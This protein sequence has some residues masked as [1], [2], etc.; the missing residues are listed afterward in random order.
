M[1]EES[2]FLAIFGSSG[3]SGGGGGGVNIYNADGTILTGRDVTITDFVNFGKLKIDDSNIINNMIL[4]GY[5]GVLTD[6][7]NYNL[8][9]NINGHLALNSTALINFNMNN[10]LCGKL[11]NDTTWS[12]G[13]QQSKLGSAK[14]EIKSANTLSTA[15]ALQIYDGDGTPSLLWD[16]RNNG[17]VNLGKDSVITLNN[18]LKIESGQTYVDNG[19]FNP[20]VINRK[21]LG[22]LGNGIDFNA[23]NSSNAETN[24]ARIV[25]VSTDATAGSEDGGLWL[26]T[27]IAGTL[28]TPVIL[29]NREF[30][31]DAV[32]FTDNA[33]RVKDGTTDCLKVTTSKQTYIESGGF[34]PLVINYRGSGVNGVGIDLNAYNSSNVEHNFAR[35]VQVA[36]DITTASEDGALWLRVSVNGTITTKLKINS[37]SVD[38]EDTLDM[39]NNRITNTVVN[40][41]VQEVVSSATF[42]VNSDEET[43]GFLT[44]MAVAT[45]IASPTGT[46]VQGQKLVYRL[47]D[48]GTARALT[49]NAIFR[50]IGVTLPTTTTASKLLYVGCFYNNTDTKWDVISVQEEA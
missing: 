49:W 18:T 43:M 25:Q 11:H 37:D 3:S 27:M 21:G 23:Y 32:N 26:R 10:V 47:K 31:I 36:T 34:N 14:V 24:F 41:S 48:D 13:S 4:L 9:M 29:D 30:L 38:I 45:T 44:A 16:F 40:P 2:R 35:I 33:F 7:T 1:S 22:T 46:P 8:L 28:R 19:S 15:S 39:N 6:I 20:L 5:K 12:F 42:T 50:A 17:D